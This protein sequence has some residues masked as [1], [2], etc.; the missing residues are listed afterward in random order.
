M[1]VRRN[2]TAERMPKQ[3][4]DLKSCECAMCGKELLAE[5]EREQMNL[6]GMS[7]AVRIGDRPYCPSCRMSARVRYEASL[8]KGGQS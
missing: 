5:S 2:Y 8:T 6:H 1:G 4:G 7:V 3:R